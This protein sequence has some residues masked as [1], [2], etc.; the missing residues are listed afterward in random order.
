MGLKGLIKMRMSPRVTLQPRVRTPTHRNLVLVILVHL[1]KVRVCWAPV[2]MV[3]LVRGVDCCCI[4][5]K[6]VVVVYTIVS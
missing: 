3:T 4:V 2:A 6:S 1:G 5:S